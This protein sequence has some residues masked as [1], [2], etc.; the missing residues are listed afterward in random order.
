MSP[1]PLLCLALVLGGIWIGHFAVAQDTP[2]FNQGHSSPMLSSITNADFSV[3]HQISVSVPTKLKVERTAEMLSVTIDTNGFEST[4]LMIGTNVVTGV[5]GWLFVYLVGEPRPTNW[6]AGWTD[7]GLDFNFGTIF[8]H[9]NQ[10]GFPQPDK[11]YVVEMDLAVFETDTPQ[12]RRI[13][14]WSTN[15]EIIWQRTLKQVVK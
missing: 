14:P 6:I 4:N 1:K 8:S 7:A 13:F 5:Q 11:S 3:T 12:D 9:A 15:Y 2:E 10:V